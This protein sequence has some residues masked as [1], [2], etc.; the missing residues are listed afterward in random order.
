MSGVGEM[1]TGRFARSAA[2]A[3][4]QERRRRDDEVRISYIISKQLGGVG[5]VS[6]RVEPWMRAMEVPM[7]VA[8]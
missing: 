1:D 5:M 6:A 7:R 4:S 8:N 3:L 2:L